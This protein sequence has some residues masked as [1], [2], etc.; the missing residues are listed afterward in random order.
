[1]VNVGKIYHT[2]ILWVLIFM[3]LPFTPVHGAWLGP[4]LH[5]IDTH[6]RTGCSSVLSQIDS[7]PAPWCLDWTEINPICSMYGI[8]TYMWFECMVGVGKY[9]IHG[10]YGHG[11]HW[12]CQCFFLLS[13]MLSYANVTDHDVFVAVKWKSDAVMCL[14]KVFNAPKSEQFTDVGALES[15]FLLG[16]PG[17]SPLWN[18]T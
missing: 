2:W 4:S 14:L 12:R 6:S 7:I 9:S 18:Q 17:V 15:I 8:D 10:V 13:D 5:G 11:E 16:F 3:A 1:M